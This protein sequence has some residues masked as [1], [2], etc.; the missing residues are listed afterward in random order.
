M[1][2]PRGGMGSMGPQ[3]PTAAVVQA[4]LLD[5]IDHDRVRAGEA[6]R[7]H[8]GQPVLAVVLPQSSGD[9]EYA[10]QVARRRH[11]ALEVRYGKGARRAID[12]EATADLREAIALDASTLTAPLAIDIGRRLATVGAGVEVHALDRAARLARLSVRGLPLW[13]ETTVGQ[14]LAAGDPGELAIG[15][16][17]FLA[18]LVAARVV[19][20]AGRS[21]Q[22]GAAQLCGLLATP[23]PGLPS[24]L[25][26][27]AGHAGRALVVCDVTVRLHRAAWTATA[28]GTLP[29]ERAALL[30]FFAAARALL[31]R[32][33]IDTLRL[34]E[35]AGS[36][37]VW[38]RAISHRD[39]ADA[40]LVAADVA[41]ALAAAHVA[42]EP[43]AAEDL[44][45][46]RGQ[47]APPHVEEPATVPTL[48]LQV[49]WPDL[50][51][52]LDVL[53]AVAGRAALP[54]E[55]AWSVAPDMVRLRLPLSGPT[56]HPLLAATPHL[57]DAGAI[58][59]AAAG[60]WRPALRERMAP[61]AKVLLTALHR[62]FDPDGLVSPGSGLP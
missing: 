4:D 37:E 30:G 12:G 58:P 2:D 47:L 28:R 51:A 17:A 39:A 62:V 49:A 8:C 45:T 36:A 40:A 9:V 38:V 6:A 32:G 33:A 25:G 5:R 43:F 24:P 61:A 21:L 29:P 31:G 11:V 60:R 15:E 56:P 19:T 54:V 20:G 34:V 55:R 44:R 27:L 50:P 57:L 48:E 18:D 52:L 22:L 16:A 59:I 26:L 53:D 3:S 46:R 1:L 35:S 42:L 10:I 13:P 14:L 41:T 7:Q 23:A